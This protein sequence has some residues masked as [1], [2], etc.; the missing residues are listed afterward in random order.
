MITEICSVVCWIAISLSFPL[1]IELDRFQ[2][3]KRLLHDYYWAMEGKIPIEDTQDFT[4]I[5]LLDIINGEQKEDQD[6]SRR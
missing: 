2:D 1:Q 4:R 3:T 5:P 6:K